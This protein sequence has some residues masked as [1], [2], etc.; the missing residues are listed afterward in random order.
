MAKDFLLAFCL[1]TQQKLSGEFPKPELLRSADNGT[2]AMAKTR[3]RQPRRRV[4]LSPPSWPAAL[5]ATPEHVLRGVRRRRPAGWSA[6]RWADLPQ[7]VILR[8]D[9]GCRARLVGAELPEHVP[10]EIRDVT[11]RQFRQARALE[12]P[13][14]VQQQERFVRCAKAARLPRLDSSDLLEPN[15]SGS[16]VVLRHSLHG[17]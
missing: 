12:L 10:H 16:G 5:V 4:A 3:V 8:V 15:L 9:S 1:L 11:K 6:N 14:G 13:Q 17:L 7:T 2:A